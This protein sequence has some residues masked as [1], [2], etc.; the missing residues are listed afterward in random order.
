MDLTKHEIFIKAFEDHE[1]S[2]LRRSFSKIGNQ[3]L[4]DDLVQ[5]TFLKT[6]KYLEK[7]GAIDS[8]KSFLFHILNN[9]IIDEY[10]KK[11]VLSLDFLKEGGFQI[12]VDDS[13]RLLNTIDGKT[14]IMLIPLL[15][16]KQRK[17]ISMRY[18]EDMS[19][20]EIA[21]ATNQPNNTV[22]VQIHRGIKNLAILF[23]VEQN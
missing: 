2:L 5:H 6:W 22:V 7:S 11:K 17:A 4:A 10:R 8:M 20:K 19:I 1:Q 21:N 18:L 23:R 16:E 15:K 14:V 9:L 3:D 12:A 13:D